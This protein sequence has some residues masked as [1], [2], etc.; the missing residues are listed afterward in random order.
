M[1]NLTVITVQQP[2]FIIICIITIFCVVIV[3]TF[4]FELVIVLYMELYQEL[5]QH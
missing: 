5:P 1:A 2:L 4:L 3:D